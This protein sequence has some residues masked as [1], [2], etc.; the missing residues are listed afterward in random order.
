MQKNTGTANED[1]NWSANIIENRIV[2]AVSESSRIAS[3]KDLAGAKAGVVS[4]A[5]AAA[6]NDNFAV[7]NSL[8]SAEAYSSANEAFAALNNG[9]ID[10]VIIDDFSLYAYPDY[11]AF[12]IIP[13]EL[14]RIEYGFAFA[15]NND[16]SAG[17]NEA[18]Y[19][20]KSPD[21]GDGD[22]LTPLAE[23]YF[24][25]SET[26]VFLILSRSKKI[27][28]YLNF[29]KKRSRSGPFDPQSGFFSLFFSTMGG[30]K[31]FSIAPRSLGWRITK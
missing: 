6:L 3:Y 13:G 7:K 22:E 16:Y 15:K 4:E 8:A 30:E 27:I 28:R 31:F 20:M 19:E 23:K 25:N 2:A 10:A 11:A 21:Y 12:K 18:V 17:F 29:N 24:G 5:A 1:Y 26:C 14:D 9:D